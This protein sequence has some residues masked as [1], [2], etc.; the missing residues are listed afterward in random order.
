MPGRLVMQSKQVRTRQTQMFIFASTNT[1]R[2]GS[3]VRCLLIQERWTGGK[4][5]QMPQFQRAVEL[6]QWMQTW[7][8]WRMHVSRFVAQTLSL[9]DE[10]P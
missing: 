3:D 6:G 1:A 5:F 7:S 4:R 10:S 9:A 2:N 8:V